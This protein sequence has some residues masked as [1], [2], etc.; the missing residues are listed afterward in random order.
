MIE[1]N[2]ERARFNMVEQQ[3]RP[4]EVLNQH[5]LDL[6][7]ESPRDE[8]VPPEYRNLA[9]ADM[10]IPLGHGQVMMSPKME[11][12]LLQELGIDKTDRIL[13][14]GTGSGYM[15]SLLAALGAHV[16][17]VEYFEDLK[18]SAA[19]KL[20][21]HGVENVTLE[22]GDAAAGWDKYQPYDVILITG[23]TPVL[24]EGFKQSLAEGGRL[25]AIVGRSPVMEVRLLQRLDE[26]SWAETALFE[27]DLPPLIHAEEP[28]KFVF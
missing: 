1:T 26:N 20:A 5:V 4:W 13:E 10:R 15:T 25:I 28:E 7:A 2:L 21:E 6:I 11:A 14:V 3:I 9:Y 23:S 22:T 12:R 8:Y 17:S 16:Y 19:Q 18:Q 27:T 24:P